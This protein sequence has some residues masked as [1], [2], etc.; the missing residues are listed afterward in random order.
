MLP[1]RRRILVK[2]TAKVKL[3]RAKDGKRIDLAAAIPRGRATLASSLDGVCRGVITHTVTILDSAAYCQSSKS[4]DLDCLLPSYYPS[5]DSLPP[6]PNTQI[7]YFSEAFTPL[8]GSFPPPMNERDLFPNPRNRGL[9]TIGGS[10]I[11]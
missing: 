1:G 9:F 7:A 11:L 3:L 8:L 4:N 10:L 6:R 2:S 5:T